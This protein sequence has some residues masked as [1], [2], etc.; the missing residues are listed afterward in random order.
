[1]KILHINYSNKGGAANACIRL[2]SQL[3]EDG[4]NSKVLVLEK[5]GNSERNVDYFF[6]YRNTKSIDRLANYFRINFPPFYNQN[7]IKNEDYLYDM[8]SFP[9]SMVDVTKHPEYIST[10]LIHL[11]HIPYFIDYKSFFK[12]NKKPVIW[13]LHDMNP[14]SGGYHSSG[15]E[16][17]VHNE[18]QRSKEL[19][20]YE[21]KI[22][23]E[24][25]NIFKELKLLNIVAPSQWLLNKSSNSMIF[26]N[27]EHYFIP[28]GVNIDEFKPYN[29]NIARSIFKIP[30]NKKIIL[31]IADNFNR[32]NKGL[33]FIL[34]VS[35][36]IMDKNI[37]FLLVGEFPNILQEKNNMQLINF[38]NDN[39]LL[40]LIYS[41]ADLTVIPSIN[42]SFSLTTLESLACGTPTVAFDTTGPREIIQH[43]KNGYLAK[44]LDLEDMLQGIL[45]LLES[46]VIRKSYS[47]KARQHILENFD[48]TQ[49][50]KKY[51][52]IY[53]KSLTNII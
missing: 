31:C 42:E 27:F 48:I 20:R 36:M 17:L 12:K 4:I 41:S 22:L 2:H 43:K 51:I 10:D 35:E 7:K 15:F 14:F 6:S 39:R 1:M 25:Q 28:H 50:S 18:I 24:K 5:K 16:D 13:T 53:Q 8:F 52:E 33:D 30:L 49:T 9:Y 44:F 34:K 3:I 19:I 21:Q 23:K 32:K 45:T 40:P 47:Q 26:K 29:Q 37:I 11:H 38:I 46:E